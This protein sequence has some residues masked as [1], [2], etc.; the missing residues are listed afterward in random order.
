MGVEIPAD[1]A[2]TRAEVGDEP[3]HR[4]LHF[5]FIPVLVGFKPGLVVAGL[6][7]FQEPKESRTE[8][9]GLG[10]LGLTSVRRHHV[11]S[12]IWSSSR[13][14]IRQV[15]GRGIDSCAAGPFT[16][17]PASSGASRPRTSWWAPQTRNQPRAE[18]ISR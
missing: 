5:L 9:G 3:K 17:S 12:H 2:Q 7:L 4:L 6:E 10:S 13:L 16:S 11:P 14:P 8:A 1:R 18:P 15:G